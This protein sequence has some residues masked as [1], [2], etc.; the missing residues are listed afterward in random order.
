MPPLKP[1]KSARKRAYLALQSLGEQ[2]IDL[3]SEQL[4]S[5]SLDEPLSDAVRTAK[6]MKAHGALRRQKQ[7]IGKLIRDV[8]PEPIRLA[9]DALGHHD[10]LAK[11]ENR[12]LRDQARS[13]EAATHDKARRLIRRT[14]F[15]EIHKELASKMQNMSR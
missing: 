1:S 15:S 13:Y 9:I 14:M 11:Q 3:T 8:D 2:L 5:I 12:A 6:S 10:N 7:L 4:A